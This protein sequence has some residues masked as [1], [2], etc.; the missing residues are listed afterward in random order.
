MAGKTYARRFISLTAMVLVVGALAYAFWPRPT[1]VDLGSVVTGP[2]RVTIAEEARTQVHDPYTV[3]TPITGRLLRLAVEPGDEVTAQKTV[4]ARM[5]PTTP[6]ALDARSREQARGSVTAAEA[7]LRVAQAEVNKARADRDLAEAN[8]ARTQKLFDSDI[9]SQAALENDARTARAAN[10]ALDTARAA[11]SMR[12]AELNNA[13][14]ALQNFDGLSQ[15]GASNTQ[16]DELFSLLAPIS[17]RILQVLQR[18]E[19]TLPAGTPIVEIGDIRND[20]EV[21]SEMLSTDAV[22]IAPGDEVIIDQWGGEAPL[23]GVVARIEPRGFT[24]VSALGVEEQRVRVTIRFTDPPETRTGLGH[25]FRVEAQVVTWASDHAV[26]VPAGALFRQGTDWA[27]FT[28][29]GG[30][31]QAQTVQIE[32]NNGLQAAISNG[33]S[34]GDTIVLYPPSGLE[35][36]QRVAQRA[37]Y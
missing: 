21:V 22:Q 33:V 4:V 26:I 31:A 14:A 3:S 18:S 9:A 34:A 32:A 29:D 1:L 36:G 7:A 2:M 10:A 25:G 37:A 20:L 23:N 15:N 16:Q 5:L 27:V 8:L 19:T 17:G 12:V 35:D 11:I 30:T 13:E 6:T 24:K 28:V